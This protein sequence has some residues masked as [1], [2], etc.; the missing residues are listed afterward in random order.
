MATSRPLLG[1]TGPDRFFPEVGTIP[2]AARRLCDNC[3]VREECLRYAID[4]EIQFG[5]WGGMSTRQRQR[6][7]FQH[8]RAADAEQ[9]QVLDPAKRLEKMLRLIRLKYVPRQ[10]SSV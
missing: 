9:V 2:A 3:P 6:Y 10:L 7:A 8:A 1:I 5:I 4:E